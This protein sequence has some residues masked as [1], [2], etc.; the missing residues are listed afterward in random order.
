MNVFRKCSTHFHFLPLPAPQASQSFSVTSLAFAVGRICVNSGSGLSPWWAV[1]WFP[2]M[3]ETHAWMSWLIWWR[4]G[5]LLSC[6]GPM[7][8]KTCFSYTSW[9]FLAYPQI[10]S[11][12]KTWKP[13]TSSADTSKPFGTVGCYFAGPRDTTAQWLVTPASAWRLQLIR[14]APWA[15]IMPRGF[16]PAN[17]RTNNGTQCGASDS[18][19][20]PRNF[21][22]RRGRGQCM[23]EGSNF[24]Y[25]SQRSKYC[26]I[27]SSTATVVFRSALK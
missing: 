1:R 16:S 5:F 11:Q 14:C 27:R 20:P 8:L 19:C 9:I 21:D 7:A 4:Y 2:R 17:R 12:N 6:L 3:E 10:S 22:C 18:G 23:K 15:I 13:T 24:T 25:G 26:N